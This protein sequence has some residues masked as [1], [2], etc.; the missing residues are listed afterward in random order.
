MNIYTLFDGM[1]L[2]CQHLFLQIF[3]IFLL[4]KSFFRV[5]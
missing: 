2:P 3:F 4:K 5:Y 1:I